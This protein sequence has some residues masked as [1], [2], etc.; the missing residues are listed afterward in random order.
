MIGFVEI[1]RG[2]PVIVV[3]F[4]LYFGFPTIGV[5]LTKDPVVAGIVG[6]RDVAEPDEADHEEAEQGGEP[7]LRQPRL[8]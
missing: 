4:I 2:M 5:T 6:G 8:R 7:E 3:L 1:F